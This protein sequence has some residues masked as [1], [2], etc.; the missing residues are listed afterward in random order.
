MFDK[1]A[2]TYDLLNRV[3]S[4]GLDSGWRRKAVSLFDGQPGSVFL[5]IAAGSGDVSLCLLELRPRMVIGADFSLPMLEI[6]HAKLKEKSE[7]SRVTLCVCDALQLPFSGGSFHGVITAF[8][9]RNFADKLESLRE[10]LRV[11]K[12]GG[13]AVILELSVPESTFFR[14]VYFL[15][16]SF[17][18]PLL[19]RFLSGDK[20]AY[21]YLPRSIASFP[22]PVEFLSLMEA[23]GFRAVES[24]VLSLGVVRIFSGTKLEARGA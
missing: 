8:G 15:H 11:L 19:G 22:L 14:A 23:A 12:P 1:I 6:F 18:L 16:A 4:L 21:R 10:M 3:I 17:V 2:P 13:K 5:D 7:D 9:I 24:R 20:E